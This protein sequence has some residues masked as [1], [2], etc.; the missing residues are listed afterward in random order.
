MTEEKERELTTYSYISNHLWFE[1][2]IGFEIVA[3]LGYKNTQAVIK[4]SVSKCNQLLFREYPG[5]REPPLN[6]KTILLTRD[7]VIEIL[8]KTRK[9]ITPDVELLLKQFGIKTTNR[10]CLTKEQNTL[11]DISKIFKI[12]KIETQYPV[13]KYFLDMYFPEYK[14]IVECDELGHFDRDPVEERERVDYINTCLG[15]DDTHWVRFNPD[16]EDFQISQIVGE[17]Y[18]AISHLK[19]GKI[20]TKPCRICKENKVCTEFYRSKIS[21]DGY[22]TRCKICQNRIS[23]KIVSSKKT[24]VETLLKNKI[25]TRCENRKSPEEFHKSRANKDGYCCICKICDSATRKEKSKI[26]KTV[27]THKKCSGCEEVKKSYNFFALSTSKDGLNGRC[28]DCMKKRTSDWLKKSHIKIS[29][30]TCGKCGETKNSTDFYKNVQ[31]RDGHYS[32]CKLCM[33]VNR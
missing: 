18:M 27:P 9:L 19:N 23:E 13:G 12:E 16:K 30:K 15:V 14:L 32:N 1:Y 11:S 20:F 21:A 17:I 5:V 4:N 8:L 33:N 10:K 3:L 22:N 29:E 31:S 25:C 24:T 6:P 7:G 28:K 2:F 26:E